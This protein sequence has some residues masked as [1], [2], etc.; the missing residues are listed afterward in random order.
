[1][2]TVIK[3]KN[4][5]PEPPAWTY[6]ENERDYHALSKSGDV[7][8]SGMLKKFRDCPY[9]Y[10][11]IISGLVKE[12]DSPAFRFGR[13][14]HKICLEG[15]PA[16]NKA[17]AIGGPINERTGKS[18][19]VGTKAHDEWLAANGYSRD[20]V[21]NE[22]EGDTLVTMANSVRKH[23]QASAL[24]D[25]GWPELVARTLLHG[26]MCQIRIDWL[27]HDADGNFCIVDLKTCSDLSWFQSDAYRYGYPHQFAFYRD[28]CQAVTGREFRFMVVA[29]EKEEPHRTGLWHVS[30]EVLDMHSA[31]NKEAL[32]NYKQCKASDVWPTGY[33]DMRSF[34][35]SRVGA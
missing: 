10:H 13:A 18:F 25:F 4:T 11:R 24:L 16:F 14:V 34:P 30:P 26:V 21:I 20:Q 2:T 3:A 5:M 28:V 7:M 12:S 33:E 6:I 17:Y 31:I 27:T 29:V 32:E 9:Q 35:T 8:S 19:G 23:P 22:D 15:I 1:M